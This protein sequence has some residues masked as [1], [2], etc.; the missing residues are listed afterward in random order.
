MTNALNFAKQHCAQGDRLAG[1]PFLPILGRNHLVSV[2]LLSRSL[3][4][5]GGVVMLV[6]SPSSSLRHLKYRR[7]RPAASPLAKRQCY[8]IQ[9]G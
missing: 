4:V 1:A 8:I 3:V 7:G 6:N 9:L 5:G 2:D